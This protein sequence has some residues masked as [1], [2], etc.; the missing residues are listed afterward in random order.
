MDNSPESIKS[1]NENLARE[2]LEL[3]S[4][5]VN[6][7]YTLNDIQELAKAISGWSITRAADTRQGFKYRPNGH[8]PGTRTVLGKE[9]PQTGVD[10]GKAILRDLAR[11][12][13]TARL[14]CFKLAR[15]FIS[16]TPSESLV[17]A[18]TDTWS[19][20]RGNLHAVMTTLIQ[21]SEAWQSTF[22]K[23]KTPREFLISTLRLANVSELPAQRVIRLLIHL[24]Q[25]PFA[26][27]SPAG[28]DDTADAWDGSG[29]LLKRID[30]VNQMS[31]RFKSA[32]FS[33]KQLLEN[34]FGSLASD[35]TRL[36]V[37]GA[38][39]REMA[40]ALFLMSPEFLRR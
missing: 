39:S 5:G 13:A 33:P 37:G 22:E 19:K 38:E 16:D 30:W 2:I 7:G 27:G 18:L 20:T 32:Q 17:K 29:A 14:V 35:H 26:A 40:A 6:G 36:L 15:H 10:Q 31:V 28:Y 1:L 21:H 23:Y 24:G 12:P 34:Y 11:H 9:Y 8:E 3:H 25:K 4:L